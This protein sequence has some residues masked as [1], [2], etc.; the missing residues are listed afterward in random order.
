M[1]ADRGQKYIINT[2]EGGLLK[3]INHT[4]PIGDVRNTFVGNT[5][6]DLYHESINALIAG[7]GAVNI[8]DQSVIVNSG[9]TFIGAVYYDA[10]VYH[11]WADG[12]ITYIYY[13]YDLIGQSEDYPGSDG[14]YLYMDIDRGTSD[15]VIT[16]NVKT[17]ILLNLIDMVDQMATTTYKADYNKVLYDINPTIELTSPKFNSLSDLSIGGGLRPGS[18]SYSYRMETLA[19]EKTLWSPPTPFI[20]VPKNYGRLPSAYHI[21]NPGGKWEGSNASLSET[22]YGISINCRV[23]NFAGFKYVE[24]KRIAN[25]VGG[26]V[27][28][29]SQP[30][31]YTMTD[32][33]L[34]TYNVINF[35]D[36][37]A[38]TWAPLD[39][40]DEFESNYIEKCRTARFYDGR[41]IIGGVTYGSKAI[42]AT[43]IFK[44]IVT[45][46]HGIPIKED[47]GVNGYNNMD[48]QVYKKSTRL[49]D[50]YSYGIRCNDSMGNGSFIIPVPD[51][52]NYKF[53]ER[54]EE[55]PSA[56][57]IYSSLT[58]PTVAPVDS[59]ASE[60]SLEKTYEVFLQ[61]TT[62]KALY[63]SNNIVTSIGTY[64]PVTPTT[65]YGGYAGNSN[66]YSGYSETP[67]YFYDGVG[68]TPPVYSPSIL[69]TGMKMGGLDR[70]ELPDW[71]SGFSYVR[72]ERANR[73]V[74]QGIGMY[75][76]TE[77]KDATTPALPT[78]ALD[79]LWI[80]AP[81][82]DSI[83]GDKSSLYED[84]KDNPGEYQIQLVSPVGFTPE[85]YNGLL[86]EDPYE[87]DITG[88]I[89]MAAHACMYYG[90]GSDINPN[91]ADEDI[92]EGNGHITFGKWR[93]QIAVGSGVSG[94]SSH[95]YIFDISVAEDVDI[96]GKNGRQQYLEVTLDSNIYAET[97]FSTGDS[98]HATSRA[99]HEPW[100]VINII[101][102]GEVA[103]DIYKEI[104]HHILLDSTIGEGTG[105]DSQTFKLVSERLGD[106]SSDFDV[107]DTTT[108]RYVWVDGKP[109]LNVDG[110]TGSAYNEIFNYTLTEY[111]AGVTYFGVTIYG[112]YGLD[113]RGD[114]IVF[115]KQ[116]N[117]DGSYIVPEL[118]DTIVVKYDENEPIDVFLGDTII[119]ETSF[120]PIDCESIEW[121]ASDEAKDKEFMLYASFPYRGF[122]I[123][124]SYIIPDDVS[125]IETDRYQVGENLNMNY[126]RQMLVSFI[127]ESS[128][129]FPMLSGDFYPHASYVMRPNVYDDKSDDETME[130]YLDSLNIYAAY[131]TD[132]HEE[133]L[134]WGYGGFRTPQTYNFD[135]NKLH[136]TRY[137]SLANLAAT[138]ITEYPKRLQ[139]TSVMPDYISSEDRGARLF[140]PTNIYD[141]KN[142]NASHINI[143]YDA[144]TSKGSSLYAI[145]DK[146]VCLLLTNKNI[147]RDGA[148]DGLGLMV[149]KSGYIGDSIWISSDIGCATDKVKGKVEGTIITSNNLSIPV[150]LFPH[151]DKIILLAENSLVDISKGMRSIT[152]DLLSEVESTE[153][154]SMAINKQTN[155]LWLLVGNRILTYGFD[156]DRWVQDN[157]IASD[158]SDWFLPSIDELQAMYDNLHTE[159]VGGFYTTSYWSS[160]ENGA[161]SAI[162]H[163][164]SSGSF[165]AGNKSNTL[166]VRACRTFT[167]QSGTYALRDTGPSGGLIFYIDG[168]TYYEAAPSDQSTSVA[169]SDVTATLIG[170]T[171]TAIG[172]GRV[173]TNLINNQVGHTT[174]AA[175]ECLDYSVGSGEGL[176]FLLDVDMLVPYI[177]D[178]GAVI[179]DSGGDPILDSEGNPMLYI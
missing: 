49:G 17:P 104:G 168:T 131:D 153:P 52:T 98:D 102:D 116:S 103:G 89:D 38:I 123:F 143:L 126:V 107:A 27:D 155:S 161:T 68:F 82:I 64:K 65:R 19:G 160:S 118:G 23:N 151:S 93:N 54:R 138:E 26:P 171:G 29:T 175:K 105:E 21:Y 31:V 73:V 121:D 119:A 48:A 34:G 174:S 79:K 167:A 170:T 124:G 57:Q 139:W 69:A 125:G 164:F 141:I 134:N 66:K 78:K 14:T 136:S 8:F 45:G 60:Y 6:F 99:S 85:M 122:R 70:S 33:I 43:S 53:P 24:I 63:P 100:Y 7:Q 61:G 15:L 30:E 91:D 32:E 12:S 169:W 96:S 74:A 111:R 3:D 137:V 10:H 172:A 2:F 86:K 88:H 120:T 110:L 127:C 58:V 144:Y 145:T 81:E 112:I 25:N 165:G 36:S 22:K 62:P 114:S 178:L 39:S 132:Y 56:E 176:R 149:A 92:G 157:E 94:D 13:D 20:P 106:V 177:Q 101:R 47:L 28:Y 95:E 162:N 40:T 72:T 9:L 163:N 147:L 55:I 71:V 59:N 154:L 80:Y 87:L 50:R 128:I 113:R 135:Y 115:N 18:Y 146:G 11:F 42:D 109:W 130:E 173:N 76:I 1:K 44:D 133:Y 142:N 129:N 5:F 67:A 46:K 117:Y 37:A 148:S 179:L 166:S 4:L 51:L 90:G 158:L 16:D 83:I 156:V 150:L 159:G 77:G 41:L 35:V 108:Y 75:A 84:I 140:L 97:D 152:K